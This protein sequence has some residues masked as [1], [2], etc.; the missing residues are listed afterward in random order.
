[1]TDD[2][3][4]PSRRL[5]LL[6]PTTVLLLVLV[7]APIGLLL[8]YS[9]APGG[10]TRADFSAGLTLEN[11]RDVLGDL[12]YLRIILKTIGISLIVTAGSILLGWPL[13]YF[14][15][16][17]PL[18]WKSLLTVAV[19]APLLI[20]IPVRNYGWLIILGDNGLVNALLRKAGAFEDLRKNLS[21]PG[22][23]EQL[24]VECAF[25]RAFGEN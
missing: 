25:L 23:Q 21:N 9:F 11:Y 19:V 24:A 14:L 4:S 2:R 7:V 20:S 16:R 10:S 3:T 5:A 1:M 12:F 15:W 18:R 8:G 17:V 6:A 22:V 13:A